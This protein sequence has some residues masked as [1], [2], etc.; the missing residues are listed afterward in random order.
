MIFDHSV[1]EDFARKSDQAQLN[2]NLNDDKDSEQN[3]KKHYAK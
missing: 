3:S 1:T 2:I